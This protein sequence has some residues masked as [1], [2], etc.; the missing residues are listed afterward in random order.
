VHDT[1]RNSAQYGEGVYVGSANSNWDKYECIDEI[2]GDADGD[3][4]ERVLI[5][6]NVSRTSPQ[7]APT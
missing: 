5:E 1:G 2:E 4:T 3:N 7:R 6:D